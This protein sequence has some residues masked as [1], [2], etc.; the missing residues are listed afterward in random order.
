MCRSP[1]YKYSLEGKDR[2][3]TYI[4][5]RFLDFFKQINCFLKILVNDFECFLGDF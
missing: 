1:V 2:N 3:K 4:T 5:K